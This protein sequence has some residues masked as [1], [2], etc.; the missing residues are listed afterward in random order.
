MFSTIGLT[1]V[2]ETPRGTSQPFL[3]I[4]F[5]RCSMMVSP[6]FSKPLLVNKDNPDFDYSALTPVK[7]APHIR[8]LDDNSD[9]L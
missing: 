1:F 9:I 8:M 4:G 2:T 7:M 3:K 5:L 6:F